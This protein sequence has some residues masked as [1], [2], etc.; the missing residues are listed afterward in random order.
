MPIAD[1]AGDT[2]GRAALEE[3]AREMGAA[4]EQGRIVKALPNT[5]EP[6]WMPF[7][8]WKGPC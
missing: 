4:E 6:L 3:V 7:P 1:V 2:A 8:K 5:S